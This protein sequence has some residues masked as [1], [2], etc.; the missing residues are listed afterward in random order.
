MLVKKYVSIPHVSL[1][2]L[3]IIFLFSLELPKTK[4]YKFVTGEFFVFSKVI[5]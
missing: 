2:I 1:M 4:V 3:L 5:N